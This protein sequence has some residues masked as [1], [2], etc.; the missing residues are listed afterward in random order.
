MMV[1]QSTRRILES[2]GWYEGREIDVAAFSEFCAAEGIETPRA[3]ETFLREFGNLLLP[4]DDH[5]FLLDTRLSSFLSDAAVIDSKYF[6]SLL[7]A[8]LGAVG[9][10]SSGMVALLVGADGAIFGGTD[11]S[12][13]WYGDDYWTG[14][15]AVLANRGRPFVVG[16]HST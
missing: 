14:L 8:P 9:M 10:A 3:A 2:A 4:I 12:L 13:V 6:S 1:E 16:L 15:E 5:R 11:E 7:Q